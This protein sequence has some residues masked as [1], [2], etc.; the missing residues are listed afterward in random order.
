MLQKIVGDESIL[1]LAFLI[2]GEKIAG[3]IV[4]FLAI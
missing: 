3:T 4:S 2:K 1:D